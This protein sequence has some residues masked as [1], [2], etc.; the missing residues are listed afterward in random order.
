MVG[1]MA[2]IYGNLM[3]ALVRG[4][5]GV[6]LQNASDVT[7]KYRP[8]RMEW[9]VE[10]QS[11]GATAVHLEIAPSA[12]GPGMVA[13]AARGERAAGRFAGMGQWRGHGAE[14]AAS[15]GCMTM[16]SLK[17]GLDKRGFVPDD[18]ENNHVK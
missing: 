2:N 10:D 14:S 16:T 17:S 7:S 9:T 12:Q 4:G 1:K 11:W 8:G 6:W 5:Q 15:S 18:C 13:H 3:F